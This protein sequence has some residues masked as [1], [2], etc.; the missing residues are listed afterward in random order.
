MFDKNV[1][2]TKLSGLVGYDAPLNPDF[3]VLDSDNL[4]SRSGYKYTDTPYAKLEALRDTQ[5]FAGIDS[6][7]FNQLL[8]TVN[9]NAITSV[10]NAVFSNKNTPSFV[11]RQKVYKY[12]SN[13][14]QIEELLENGFVGHKFCFENKP[15]ITA[16]ITS[17]N[18]DFQGT[19]DV[20][21][22]LYNTQNLA[23]VESKVVTIT[24]DNQEEK[25]G[26]KMYSQSGDYYLGYIYDGT[27]KPFKRSYELANIESGITYLR[28]YKRTVKGFVGGNIWDVTKDESTGETTGLNPDVTVFND[29]TDLIVQNEQLFANAIYL[30]GAISFLNYVKSSLR[31]NKNQRISEANLIAIEQ[32]IEGQEGTNVVRITGLRPSLGEQI[33]LIQQRIDELR[34]GYFTGRIKTVTLY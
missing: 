20:T 10:C 17:V 16:E 23:P 25:L 24:G 32:T 3:F 6:T 27:L 4:E 1:V 34:M 8:R 31:S 26:W 7:Q 29:Y 18:L 19:G 33:G 11:D 13:K 22:L 14:S 12:A 15:N 21:V 28:H 30:Q 2:Q 5:D 9:N